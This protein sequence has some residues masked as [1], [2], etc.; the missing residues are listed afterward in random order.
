MIKKFDIFII[1]LLS[2][3][4]FIIND[5]YSLF[6]LLYIILIL[7]YIYKLYKYLR[8]ELKN[9][10]KELIRFIGLSFIH[11]LFSYFLI[12]DPNP[13]YYLFTFYF[14]CQIFFKVLFIFSF[15]SYALAKFDKNINNTDNQLIITSD[16]YN[17]EPILNNEYFFEFKFN[18]FLSDIFYYLKNNKKRLY[19]LIAC[20]IL[21]KIIIFYYFSKIWIVFKSKETILPITKRKN[22]QFY[23]TACIANIEPIIKD[24]INE[25][26]KL[27]NYLDEKNVII[28]IVENGDSEDNTR[29]YL[30]EFK[31]Y[32]DS[33][34]VI[35]KFILTHEIEDPRKKE[36][37]TKKEKKYLR[38]KYLATLRNKCFDLLYQFPNLDFNKIKIIYLNDII[39]NYQ[40]IIKLISTNNEDYDVVCAMDYYFSFYDSWVSI[41]LDGNHLLQNFPYFINKEAQDQY[42]NNKP[43]RTFSCWNG[44]VSFNASALKNKQLRFRSQN[45]I[46]KNNKEFC[47]DDDK[48]ESECT[49]FNIDM[50]TLG[51][52]KRFINPGVKVAYNYKYYYFSKYIL[53]YTF[54]LLFYFKN[55]LMSLLTKRNKNMSDLKSIN[56]TL[57]KDLKRWYNCKK[58]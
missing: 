55:Y 32:L 7:F 19:Q 21:L 14:P 17:K 58:F 35:N 22:F 10:I 18:F 6:I 43:I 46:N 34:L 1:S 11:F 33:K 44:V 39:F 57:S 26:K 37:L 41:D 25:L 24:Y 42:I 9:N 51:F 38:I 36:Y 8:L 5:E 49:Y 54:E 16:N 52:T 53:P 48:Y 13:F 27:I 28:S 31:G 15:H 30:K 4:Y 40:D 56:I 45:D 3:L 50:E 23:V 47:G 12:Y 29:E 2:I 20:L